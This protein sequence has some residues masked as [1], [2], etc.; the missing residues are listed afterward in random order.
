M[1]TIMRTSRRQLVRWG[2]GVDESTNVPTQR[3]SSL[4]NTRSFLKILLAN[5]LQT[6][7]SIMTLL[8]KTAI[9][10]KACMH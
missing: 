1:D 10:L 6:C 7:F 4:E 8:V 2:W 5:L 9:F 3:M